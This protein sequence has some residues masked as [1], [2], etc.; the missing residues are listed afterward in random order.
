MK[1]SVLFL[2]LLL[3]GVANSATIIDQELEDVSQERA[4]EMVKDAFFNKDVDYY[5]CTDSVDKWT[6]FVDAEPL[7]GWEHKC[8]IA[9][10][11]KLAT[12]LYVL[13]Y[14]VD[15]QIIDTLKFSK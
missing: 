7:K 1:Y 5:L 4:L 15:G 12:G 6:F 11:P 8:F 2:S 9:T 10:I 3:W 14:I 13:S